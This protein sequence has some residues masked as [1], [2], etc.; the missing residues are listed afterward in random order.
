MNEI[1]AA[2]VGVADRLF[3]STRGP[4]G[5]RDRLARPD[6]HWR[7]EYSA[8]ETAVTWE[9][10][11]LSSARSS[12]RLSPHNVCYHPLAQP[13]AVA[14]RGGSGNLDRTIGGVSA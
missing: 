1:N 6:R 3:I 5:W 4:S 10:F 12:D 13:I 8:F 14:W 9:F 2:E 7:R 11:A